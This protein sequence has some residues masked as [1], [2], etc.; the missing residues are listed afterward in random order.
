MLEVL[1]VFYWVGIRIMIMR[2]M[3]LTWRMAPCL[4]QTAILMM[5]LHILCIRGTA[6][7]KV[8]E[9]QG[10][11]CGRS[12][13]MEREVLVWQMTRSLSRSCLPHAWVAVVGVRTRGKTCTVC[14]E[15]TRWCSLLRHTIAAAGRKFFTQW[16]GTGRKR[17]FSVGSGRG[18]KTPLSSPALFP[19]ILMGI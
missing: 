5:L 17:Q 10:K 13:P 11:G 2:Q 15:S 18:C 3:I 7:P 4:A 14:K 9:V 12:I 1:A 16:I 8:P 6:V 19:A